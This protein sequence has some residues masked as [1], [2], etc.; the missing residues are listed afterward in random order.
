M[1][2]IPFRIADSAIA[3]RGVF[4]L[5][6]IRQGQKVF[7]LDGPYITR[8]EAI[9][10][11]KLDYAM[12]VSPDLSHVGPE[13][14]INHSCQPNL[15]FIDDKTAVALVDIVPTTELTWDYSVLTV[16]NWTMRC[17]CPWPECRKKIGNY[18]DLPPQLRERLKAITPPWVRAFD[19][20]DYPHFW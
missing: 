16:D 6:H 14:F 3:G 1:F 4:P 20:R 11:G 10:T 7:I 2:Y 13:N 18:R 19:A 17:E 8:D 15:G 5:R 9:A 12:P